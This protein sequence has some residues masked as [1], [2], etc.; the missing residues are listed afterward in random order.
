[1]TR[2]P[3]ARYTGAGAKALWGESQVETFAP[4]MRE[5]SDQTLTLADEARFRHGLFR[6]RG[7]RSL[8]VTLGIFMS[9]GRRLPSLV[10]GTRVQQ[11]RTKKRSRYE[12]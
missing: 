12:E 9:E 1:M 6:Q 3:V 7:E 2:W 5:A 4:E 11:P 8:P 10:K